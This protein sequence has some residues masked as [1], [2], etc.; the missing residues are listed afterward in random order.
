M[1][2]RF[3]VNGITYNVSCEPN[4]ILADLLRNRLG[5]KDVKV[6]CRSG[7]CGSCTVLLE[8]KAVDSCL[9]L[10]A[11]VNRREV[12]TIKGL[13]QERVSPLQTA[14]VEEGAIQC[15]FC[16]AGFVLTASAFLREKPNPTAEEIK[17]AIGG[18]LCRCTGYEAVIRAVK[19]ASSRPQGGIR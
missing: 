4:E 11:E 6:G 9:V 8:G 13:S 12:V 17:A 15:G 14:F 18:N 3:I 7:E 10:A 5:L 2:L 1:K 16:T 19:K